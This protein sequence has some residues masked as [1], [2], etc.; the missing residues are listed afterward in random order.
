MP[1][2]SPGLSISIHFRQ[3]EIMFFTDL[4]KSDGHALLVRTELL[5]D[6]SHHAASESLVVS[7]AG[8]QVCQT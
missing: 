8:L 5:V 1:E 6:Y 3:P 4:T 7:L 2:D